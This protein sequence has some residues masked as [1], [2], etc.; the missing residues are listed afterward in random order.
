[1][2]GGTGRGEAP[3]SGVW[4]GLIG[5]L[6]N[7]GR[8]SEAARIR[9]LTGTGAGRRLLDVGGRTGAF[10]VRFARPGDTVTVL[11]PE[12]EIVGAASRHRTAI[13]F[14]TGRGEEI[15]FPPGA[16]DVVTAVRSTHHMEA[17]ERFFQEASRVLSAGGRIVIEELAPSSGLAKLFSRLMRKRH[18]HP[19]DFRGPADWV[20]GLSEAGFEEVTTDAGTR[21]FFVSGR[22]PSTAGTAAS[23]E[24]A[25]PRLPA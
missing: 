18:H 3:S 16:F 24:P 13:Q 20:R 19:M 4:A 15:P 6:V 22:K 25:G 17:P 5:A 23:P 1:M 12:A 9:E 10:T 7:A 14:V 8:G 2:S 21:W 11:E